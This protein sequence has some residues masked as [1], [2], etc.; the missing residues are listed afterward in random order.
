MGELPYDLVN[1][2]GS[3]TSSIL[4]NEN[5]PVEACWMTGVKDWAGVMISAQTLIGRVL[6]RFHVTLDKSSNLHA[7]LYFLT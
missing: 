3:K 6:V 1:S 4:Q 2:E 7:E 5:R